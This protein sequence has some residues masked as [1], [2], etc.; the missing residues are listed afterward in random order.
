MKNQQSER[1]IVT[2]ANALELVGCVAQNTLGNIVADSFAGSPLTRD[3]IN[4]IVL[5]QLQKAASMQ[6]AA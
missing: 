4:S 3:V 6:G 5:V 1:S 2:V